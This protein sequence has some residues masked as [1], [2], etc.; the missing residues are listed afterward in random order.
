[1]ETEFR[2][3]CLSVCPCVCVCLCVAVCVCLY[4]EIRKLTFFT[5]EIVPKNITPKISMFSPISVNLVD[6][7]YIFYLHW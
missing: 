7:F 1:M 3:V 2:T 4:T 6:I 5:R